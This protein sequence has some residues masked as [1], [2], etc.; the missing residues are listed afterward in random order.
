M[1]FIRVQDLQRLTS[2]RIIL[3]EIEIQIVQLPRDHAVSRVMQTRPPSDEQKII[4]LVT[5]HAELWYV[6]PVELEFHL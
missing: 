1:I 2:L 6:T 3:F 4:V 5:R